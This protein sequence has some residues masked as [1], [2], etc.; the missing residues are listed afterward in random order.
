M[1]PP[2]IHP[3]K[4][5]MYR[6]EHGYSPLTMGLYHP[7]VMPDWL[8][9]YPLAKPP[10]EESDERD[11]EGNNSAGVV[12]CRRVDHA[13]R[14]LDTAAVLAAIP[15]KAGIARSWGLRFAGQSSGRDGWVSVHAVGREDR[16]PSA[17]F[18]LDSG[19]YTE[20]RDG[21]SL[22][23]FDL[24]ARLGVYATWQD[25]RADLARQH[26]LIAD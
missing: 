24:G 3:K 18:H 19:H 17:S 7:M 15:D 22:S 14:P 10:K 20:F 11:G 21:E 26:G 4:G 1:A 2:S 12:R 13:S 6:F 5:R 8:I 9:N 16:N 23:F 25:C